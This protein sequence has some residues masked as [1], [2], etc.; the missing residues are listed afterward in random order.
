MIYELLVRLGRNMRVSKSVAVALSVVSAVQMSM[1]QGHVR[2]IGNAVF[3]PNDGLLFGN[4]DLSCSVYQ[5][6]DAIVFRLGKSDVW[7]RRMD[8]TGCFKPVTY[9]EFVDGVLKDGWTI[10]DW[11]GVGG[12]GK[13]IRDPKRWEDVRKGKTPI[14]NVAPCPKPTGEFRVFTP[15]DLPAPAVRQELN[16]EDARVT[17]WLTWPNGCKLTVDAVIPPD[18][19]VL[20]VRW[21]FEGWTMENRYGYSLQSPVWLGVMRWADPDW[22]T[23]T[24]RMSARYPYWPLM[25][26]DRNILPPLP[27]PTQAVGDGQRAVEQA[28][29]PDELFPE[30]FKYRMYLIGDKDK[31]VHTMPPFDIEGEEWVQYRPKEDQTAGEAIV[32][33]CTTRD[34]NLERPPARKPFSEYADAA[35]KAARE[36]WAKSAVRIPGDPFLEDAWY[37]IWHTR[38]STIRP[39]AVPPGLFL[40]SVLDDFPRWNGDYHG[41]YNMQS[42]YWGDL[43]AGRFEEV[44]AYF[45]MIDWMRPTGRAIARDYY[46]M[47]GVMIQLQGFP[48]G[49][50]ADPS[51]KLPLGRMVYMTGWAMTRFWAYYKYTLD[52]EWL[53]KRGYPFM[54]ECALFYL[55]F[56]KKAPHPD[57]PPELNDGKYHVFPSIQGESGW[58]TPMDLCDRPQPTRMARYCL[59]ATEE[60]AGI[61]GVDA[62]FAAQCRDRWQNMAG[63][64]TE[65]DFHGGNPAYELHCFFGKPPEWHWYGAT[66]WYSDK[67]GWDGEL[68]LSS[69]AYGG[70]P[71]QWMT[72][73]IG[74]ALTPEIDAEKSFAHWRKCL[75]HW[76]KPSGQVPAMSAT[77]WSRQGWTE[78]NA[79]VAPF[80]CM[81]LWSWD[82]AI[83]IFPRWPKSVDA[84]FR[85][86]RAE[87]AFL[88][89]AAQKAGKVVR[90]E[91]TSEKGEDCLVHGDWQVADVS[92]NVVETDKDKFGRL[93]FKTIAGG[94]YRLWQDK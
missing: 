3:A 6:T 33:V 79:G 37:A 28:F 74:Q 16:I 83:R 66:P 29:Y 12:G 85:D 69:H 68:K 75:M 76:M 86:F 40:P 77:V 34:R 70:Y 65:A 23:W 71:G 90:F 49:S 56:M 26:W 18:E 64:P 87:G 54:K 5:E 81:M 32:A 93:R 22:K 47:R 80:Q 72:D 53:A 57:L 58:K 46:G 15:P 62:D 21:D 55:D 35:K 60:A 91:V 36:F 50:T 38:R 88:V 67:G 59:K 43:T 73:Q 17:I 25:K 27:P 7:D 89:S 51:G 13:K 11:S 9:R 14:G 39:G 19:N 84:G 63:T 92:G 45:D 78:T 24:A 8:T 4:G 30:G 2:A 1:A 20:A 42:I 31:G 41:N 94:T 44:E 52:R 10:T 61:L 82:G 48:I